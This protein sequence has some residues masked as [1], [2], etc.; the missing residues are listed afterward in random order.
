M[1]YKVYVQEVWISVTEVEAGSPE[2]A[3]ELVDQ[4][5]YNDDWGEP[6]FAYRVDSEDWEIEEIKE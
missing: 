6:E 1:K 2:E 4:V 3:K 5:E